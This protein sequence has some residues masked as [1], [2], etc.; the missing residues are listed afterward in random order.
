MNSEQFSYWL[1]GYAEIC[2][3][4]PTAEQWQIIKDHL[5]TVFKKVTP[6]RGVPITD[7][8]PYIPQWPAER[9]KTSTPQPLRAECKATPQVATV[10]IC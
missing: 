4:E 1:Q 6:Q 2:G 8:I 5:Q 9:V 10:T 3:T 7:G